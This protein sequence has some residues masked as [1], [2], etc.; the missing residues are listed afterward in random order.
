MRFVLLVIVV[1]A[2]VVTLAILGFK[3][4]AQFAVVCSPWMIADV[5][6]RRPGRHAAGARRGLPD[7]RIDGLA[8]FWTIAEPDD[9]DGRL[10]AASGG[11]GFWHVVAF[12]WICN[13]AMHVG[14]S[15]MAMFRF[16][17]G[18]RATGCTPPSACSSATT[19]PGSAR[20]S[21]APPRPTW[22]SKPLAQLDSGGRRRSTALGVSG[23][24]AVMVAG[25]TT[26]NPTLYRGRPGPPGG[27]ARLAALAG[28]AHRRGCHHARGLLPVRV[29]QAARLRRASTDCC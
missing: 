1:G 8:D 23:A 14:L 29:H 11:I 2:V 7:G 26:A 28:D 16:A 17:R 6:R 25:W 18:R 20:A 3:R 5:H 9:L 21:W 10:G 27:H 15:D 19:W 22:P 12:A 24:L 4:L 13:L